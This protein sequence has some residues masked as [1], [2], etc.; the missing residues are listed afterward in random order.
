MAT[1]INQL[2]RRWVIIPKQHR[3]ISHALDHLPGFFD[4]FL[5]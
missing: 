3:V 4:G 1:K 5:H 2:I